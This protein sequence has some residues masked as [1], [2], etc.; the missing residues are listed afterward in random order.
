MPGIKKIIL[1]II[2]AATLLSGCSVNF[3][4]NVEILGDGRPQMKR[5]D[6]KTEKNIRELAGALL[7][8][9]PNISRNEAVEL[10]HDSYVYPMYLAEKWELTWPP[11]Y[12][13]TLRNSGARKLGLCTDWAKAMTDMARKKHLR[14][15]DV[16]WG[17]AFRG[18]P[19]R[20]HSTLIVTA[21]GQP[22]DTGII[23]DP[24]R[25]SGKLYW[26]RHLEDPVYVWKYHAG[27]YA[28]LPKAGSPVGRIVQ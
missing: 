6:P 15:M 20:E 22:F 25:N 19:W 9:G 18:D 24:W 7:S 1:S 27:P 8:L 21:K 11:M 10:A 2:A 13:N 23:L 12:H 14:T 5:M 16:Y 28:P 4:D 17:V 3:N 26:I